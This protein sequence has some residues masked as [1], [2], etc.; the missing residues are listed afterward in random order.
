MTSS[1]KPFL[2]LLETLSR[3]FTLNAENKAEKNLKMKNNKF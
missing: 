3:I 2:L 1:K